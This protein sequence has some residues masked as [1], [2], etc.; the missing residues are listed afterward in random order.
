MALVRIETTDS[1]ATVEGGQSVPFAVG[2]V[3]SGR[4]DIELS[5]A[6]VRGVGVVLL[7]GIFEVSGEDDCRESKVLRKI[8]LADSD[9]VIVAVVISV[10]TDL[11]SS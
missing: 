7:D 5:V 8:V 2:V 11:V 4:V 9:G 6:N 3:M 1:V 10:M